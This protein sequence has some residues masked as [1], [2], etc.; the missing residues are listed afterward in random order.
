MA[1]PAHVAAERLRA[2]QPQLRPS[3]LPAV[4]MALSRRLAFA[5]LGLLFSIAQ[6]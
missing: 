3:A 2:K 5:S 4:L 1:R 6:F